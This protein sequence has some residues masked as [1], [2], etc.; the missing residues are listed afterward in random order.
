MTNPGHVKRILGC[1]LEALE[2]GKAVNTTLLEVT[3]I[4]SFTDFMIVS[5]GRSVRQV[6]SL[7][8]RVKDA[9]LALGVRPLGIEGETSGEW[10]LIDFGDVVVHVMQPTAREFYQLEKLWEAPRAVEAEAP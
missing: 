8:R 10:V 9:P 4:A 2:D 6:K 5:S 3:E 7:V 1:I